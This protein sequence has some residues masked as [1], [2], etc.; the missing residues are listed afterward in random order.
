MLQILLRIDQ[1]DESRKVLSDHQV[2]LPI[3]EK[4]ISAE[5]AKPGKIKNPYAWDV[6]K[7]VTYEIIE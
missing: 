3:Y 6:Y 7:N 1:T 4:G 5:L 2:I